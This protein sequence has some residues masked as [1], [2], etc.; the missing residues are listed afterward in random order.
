MGLNASELATYP[1]KRR[2]GRIG[3]PN[4]VDPRDP[5][6]YAA[7]LVEGGASS[8]RPSW[9]HEPEAWI[10]PEPV[11]E[12]V[13]ERLSVEQGLMMSGRSGV[14]VPYGIQG[15]AVDTEASYM[16][17][18]QNFA[19][20]IQMGATTRIIDDPE[21]AFPSTRIPPALDDLFNPW[22]SVS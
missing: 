20:P 4:P 7:Q 13:A 19:G 1:P 21:P 10:G 15:S 6:S 8:F 2:Q 17:G 18:P 16:V 3:R 9:L 22:S 11:G 5:S 14:G 12:A